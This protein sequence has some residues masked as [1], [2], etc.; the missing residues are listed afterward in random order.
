MGL[1]RVQTGERSRHSLA[2]HR[3][4]D[5]FGVRRDAEV[6]QVA[7][8]LALSV[9]ARGLSDGRIGLGRK[10]VGGGLGFVEEAHGAPEVSRRGGVSQ[11]SPVVDGVNR[12]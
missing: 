3:L 12:Q 1:E 10:V 7:V 4:T 11:R 8:G 5:V 2:I 6:S 9:S